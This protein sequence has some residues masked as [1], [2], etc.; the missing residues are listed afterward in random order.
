MFQNDA[1]SNVCSINCQNLPST[2][3]PQP[4]LPNMQPIFTRPGSPKII[5]KATMLVL[6]A[7]GLVSF[8]LAASCISDVHVTVTI[9]LPANL[10]LGGNF[11]SYDSD[12]NF[13]QYLGY[14]VHSPLIALC[15]IDI[16]FFVH[17]LDVCSLS[18][19]CLCL[20][21]LCVIHISYA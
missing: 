14:L 21:I 20:C 7:F 19:I 12:C 13:S 2:H 15:H 4:H 17:S 11:C 18:H 3:D 6:N 8:V 10:R 9:G 1:A 16:I 5:F